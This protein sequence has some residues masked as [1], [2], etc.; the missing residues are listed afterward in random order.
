[1]QV[2]NGGTSG[3]LAG[4]VTD[5]GI[6]IFNRSDTA[7]FGGDISGSGSLVQ[8]GGGTLVLTGSSTHTGGT[9]ISGGTL[10]IGNGGT[11]GSI[12]GNITDN[13]TLA[14]NRGDSVTYAGAIS[15]TG[16]VTKT[17]AGTLTLSGVNTYT[18]G[19]SVSS[20][21]LTV[22]G[23]TASSA[24]TVGAS[25]SL[26]GSG[27]VGSLTV[28][29]GGTVAP[30][31]GAAMLSVNGN[32]TL[33][34]GSSFAVDFTSN[35]ADRIVASGSVSLSGTLAV[36]AGSGFTY[37]QQV[38][39]ISATGGI[40]GNF[41]AITVLSSLDDNLMAVPE[42][43]GNNYFLKFQ[44]I[45]ISALLAANA[46]VNQ[47]NVAHAI[48]YAMANDK[49]R[50]FFSP[51]ANLTPAALATTMDQLSGETASGAATSAFQ[52]SRGFLAMLQNP[53]TNGR[54]AVT[55]ASGEASAAIGQVQLA[56]NGV[57]DAPLMTPTAHGRIGFWGQGFGSVANMASD[58]ATGSHSLNTS[59]AGFAM[60]ADY[61]PEDTDLVLGGGLAFGENSWH[62]TAGLGGG[63][64]SALQL[65][66]SAAAKLG[67]AYATGAAGVGFYNVKTQRTASAG[68]VASAYQA[69]YDTTGWS[70][71]AELGRRFQLSGGDGLTPYVSL[72]SQTFHMPG[73][74][75][76][77]LAGL[78]QFA[79][80]YTGKD[81]E[82]FATEL[83]GQWDT[84]RRLEDGGVLALQA[85]LGWMHDAS[86]RLSQQA[87]LTGFAGTTFTS[88]GAAS[89]GDGAHLSLTGQIELPSGFFLS[90]TADATA[91]ARVTEFG[92]RL[93]AAWRW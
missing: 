52:G 93:S 84:A 25:A 45:T 81:M 76:N 77:T 48:D 42:S 54:G 1:L 53:V 18:G 50:D 49:A 11:S 60:G 83:G 10:Q 90:A 6:L 17:G 24:V 61:R 44:P 63:H 27:T 70:F 74:A 92:G 43:D 64:S 23:S 32:V 59:A 87:V 13:G 36:N 47:Q 15:G 56:Q 2:G 88:F 67:D 75:E 51:L 80:S 33:A 66:L 82:R 41:T 12:A 57:S 40:S 19:T 73:Y 3:S 16:G 35:G 21:T 68:G 14:F 69:Q 9:V 26:A 55:G 20:G 8:A 31:P 72:Q 71:A 86:G 7:R 39:L 62:T 65:G 29:S 79:L 4:N 28:Q 91:S 5:N 22:T 37:N 30:G 78:S 46:S 34:S 38:T 89:G 85:R 58:A